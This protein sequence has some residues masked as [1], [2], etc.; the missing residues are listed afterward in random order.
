MNPQEKLEKLSGIPAMVLQKTDSTNLRLKEAARA[1]KITAPF[2]LVA[3]AQTQGRGRLG[4]SFLS[5]E[6]GLYMSLLLPLSRGKLP[7]TVI[8]A[9]AVCRAIEEMTPC[10][11]RV[12]WVNDLFWK[13]KKICGILAEGVEQG[14]VLGIG[15]NLKTPEGGFPGVPV[16]GA[17]DCDTDSI[18]LAARIARTLTELLD[19]EDES[20]ILRDYRERMLLIGK[21]VSYTQN[22]QQ[23]NA[24]VLG[25]DEAGGLTVENAEGE[26]ETL[27]T[28]EVS[29]GSDQLSAFGDDLENRQPQ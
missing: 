13:G 11:P 27:R 9:V 7:L 19:E 22:G 4:R 17:L 3:S 29:L 24:R 21:T 18:A 26:K 15:I 20:G 25:V 2:M 10:S 23:K 6:G 5:P 14:A 16:A 8:A 12:K 1:G 28:G